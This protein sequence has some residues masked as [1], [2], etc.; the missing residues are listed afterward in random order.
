[1]KAYA[2]HLNEDARQAL[3]YLEA[4][5]YSVGDMLR[6]TGA[7]RNTMNRIRRHANIEGHGPETK[8]RFT[9]VE[10]VAASVAHALYDAG[11]V[12]TGQLPGVYGALIR[13]AIPQPNHF[14]IRVT[15]PE[16]VEKEVPTNELGDF[17]RLPAEPRL[18][19]AEGRLTDWRHPQ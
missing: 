2:G 15:N 5:D 17:Y 10:V 3:A 12:R 6:A 11:L 8:R 16:F 9:G 1:M 14:R 13:N 7:D 18:V 4:T 19:C